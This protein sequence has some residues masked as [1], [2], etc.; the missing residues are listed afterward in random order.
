MLKSYI[1]KEIG[2]KELKSERKRE[3]EKPKK[4]RESWRNQSFLFFR[5]FN[6]RKSMKYRKPEVVGKRNGEKNKKKTLKK[7]G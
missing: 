1:E 6:K 2:Q 7:I 3:R 4:Q 5:N